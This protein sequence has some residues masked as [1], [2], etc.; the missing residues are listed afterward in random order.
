[1]GVDCSGLLSV[2]AY[3]RVTLKGVWQIERYEV[4]FG[5]GFVSVVP[6]P[7]GSLEL[8]EMARKRGCTCDECKGGR[9]MDYPVSW[10]PAHSLACD[11]VGC[12]GCWWPSGT[13]HSTAAWLDQVG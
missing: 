12:F 3:D 2:P 4:A 10:A 8:T 1:M 9:R 5:R 13:L 6:D 11:R 7:C